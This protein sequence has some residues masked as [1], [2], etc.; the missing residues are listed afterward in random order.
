MLRIIAVIVVLALVGIYA[1]TRQL[2]AALPPD[3]VCKADADCVKPDTCS[4][5]T[6]TCVPNADAPALILEAQEAAN[7]FY[8]LVNGMLATVT[9]KPASSAAS[10]LASDAQSMFSQNIDN[11]GSLVDEIT[12]AENKFIHDL[13]AFINEFLFISPGCVPE[14]D[15]LCGYY[16]DINS[17]NAHSDHSLVG[18]VVNETNS[19]SENLI[20]IQGS[21]L[22]PIRDP[23]NSMIYNFN[24]NALKDQ[25]YNYTTGNNYLS[26]AHDFLD[27]LTDYSTELDLLMTQ[28]VNTSAAISSLYDDN[29]G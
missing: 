10:G 15:K 24:N 25:P 16:I 8:N 28:I 19:I 11:G 20:N 18:A 13:T 9:A 6:S 14:I 17:V 2:P 27:K 22:T 4:L 23:L 12:T 3:G 29:D 26:H 5:A 1:V 7:N 21:S